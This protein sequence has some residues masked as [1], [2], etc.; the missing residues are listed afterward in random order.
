ME[1]LFFPICFIFNNFSQIVLRVIKEDVD[2]CLTDR[3][4]SVCKSC[5][6]SNRMCHA[7]VVFSVYLPGR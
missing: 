2:I 3:V 6:E 4:F 1:M 5:E 7:C